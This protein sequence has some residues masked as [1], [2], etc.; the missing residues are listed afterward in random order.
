MSTPSPLDYAPRPPMHQRRIFRLII[1]TFLFVA[2][3]ASG[4][5]WMP[6][7]WWQIELLYWEH[8][9]LAY[10]QASG[11]LVYDS[12]SGRS[13]IPHEWEVFYSKYSYPGMRSDGTIFLGK[14]ISPNGNRRLVA[15]DIADTY[16]LI[17]AKRAYPRVFQV[18]GISLTLVH[19]NQK[20]AEF[21]GWIGSS[22]MPN[23]KTEKLQVFSGQ[24]D[25]KDPSHV[26]F[27]T[28]LDGRPKDFDV[29][30]QNDD[31]VV[32]GERKGPSTLP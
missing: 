3:L 17:G 15:V 13:L 6:S 7:L 18:N 26:V 31:T 12:A 9:C 24:I 32:I 4:W 5:F 11:Q 30:L 27:A 23:S 14:L 28:R 29:W 20:S 16:N 10:V 8:E 25:S 19:P 22:M 2:V 1:G 21:L